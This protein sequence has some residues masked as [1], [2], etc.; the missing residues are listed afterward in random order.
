MSVPKEKLLSTHLF[1]ILSVMLLVFMALAWPVNVKLFLS[2]TAAWDSHDYEYVE[3]NDRK[4]FI[5]EFTRKGEYLD[6]IELYIDGIVSGQQGSAQIALLEYSGF[7]VAEYTVPLNRFSNDQF[8]KIFIGRNLDPDKKYCLRI[9]GADCGEDS[10]SLGILKKNVHIHGQEDSYY[11]SL[12]LSQELAVNYHYKN[13]MNKTQTMMWWLMLGIIWLI[14]FTIYL[15]FSWTEVLLAVTRTEIVAQITAAAG[16]VSA[17]CMA[18]ALSPAVKAEKS[19][20]TLWPSFLIWSVF[21][22]LALLLKHRLSGR[23]PRLKRFTKK[24]L[25]LLTVLA[26]SLVIRIPMLDTMQRW[27]AGEY[28]YWLGT[29]C[30]NYDF[31]LQSVFDEFRLCTH[32]NL[33]FSLI[34]AIGEFL[35]PRGITGVLALNLILTLLA[36][37]CM[38]I[39]L[40]EHWLKCGPWTAAGFT[41]MISFTPIFLGT[42]SY[43]NTDYLLALYFIF[44]LF[45]DY[46]EWHV[47]SW[48]TAVLLSQCKET[49]VLIILGYYGLKILFDFFSENGSIQKR[50]LK[51]LR[52][53]SVWISVMTG[54]VYAATIFK[55]GSIITWVQKDSKGVIASPSELKM[56]YFGFRSEHI[57]HRMKQY[58]ISNFAWIITGMILCCLLFLLIKSFRTRRQYNLKKYIGYIG[59]MLGFGLFGVVYITAGLNRY[60]ILFAVGWS[61]AGVILYYH[62]F[63]S[64]YSLRKN[65]VFI[66]FI[67]ALFFVQSFW[68]IDAI[69]SKIFKEAKIS[70]KNSMLFTDYERGNAVYYGD[71]LVNNYQ[72]SW[73]DKALDK[74]MREIEYNENAAVLLPREEATGLHINGNGKVY[75]VSWDQEKQKRVIRKGSKT[76][77][78]IQVVNEEAISGALPYAYDPETVSEDDFPANVYI[79]IF[80]Y[81]G[82]EEDKILSEIEELYY[83]SQKKKIRCYGGELEYYHGVRKDHFC[84]YSIQKAVVQMPETEI[85]TKKDLNQ[86]YIKK[87]FRQLQTPENLIYRLVYQKCVKESE[88]ASPDRKLLQPGDRVRAQVKI[89][90]PSGNYLR[91]GYLGNYENSD[92]TFELGSGQ[93]LDGIEEALI[94]AELG[95]TI[96]VRCIIPRGYLPA[97][98]YEGQELEFH[99][100][101]FRIIETVSL[102]TDNITRLYKDTK[103]ALEQKKLKET[104]SVLACYLDFDSLNYPPRDLE[105]ELEEVLGYYKIFLLNAG[106]SEQEFLTEFLRMEK[107]DYQKALT[108]I[109]KLSIKQEYIL[110][111]LLTY[112]TYLQK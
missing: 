83:I 91:T 47:L 26:V 10:F 84:G 58:F 108:E 20:R 41:L 60:N 62:A 65:A 95:R 44:L 57:I 24:L 105:K 15:N 40:K 69:S 27:D 29:A 98:K 75:I 38:Y 8:N 39:L 13:T 43:L 5:Q 51:M 93:Y 63:D 76:E 7:P 106:I 72:Y 28:Y 50:A 107:E 3:I 101:P 85:F 56:N 80:K 73:I 31:T 22:W 9:T 6:S 2:T 23:Q 74:F 25:P 36:I 11:S 96:I 109:A 49:G 54:A 97:I 110:K 111:R 89:K 103:E 88:K 61:I 81:Y 32:S 99:I 37:Y 12:C 45:T 86:E 18:A 68:N 70:G 94:G 77:T 46:K 16:I 42:F 78:E 100:M 66:L 102:N 92:Y 35:N 82:V 4:S 104:A 17:F 48:L 30:E 53:S 112:R 21:I 1:L 64:I 71:G 33:G 52:K 67:S 34:M 19:F 79:P 87:I 55:L 90:D 59:A 14:L